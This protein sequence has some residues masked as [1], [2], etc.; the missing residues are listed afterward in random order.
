MRKSYIELWSI[1]E[2]L[3]VSII[4]FILGYVSINYIHCL[5]S[6]I[7]FLLGV[8]SCHV[9]CTSRFPKELSNVPC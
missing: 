2:R 5:V 7:F 8:F 1:E 6:W 9:S 3:L 4:K